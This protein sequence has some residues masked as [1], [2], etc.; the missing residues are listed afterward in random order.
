MK[1]YWKHAISL[2][3]SKSQWLMTD[4]HRWCAVSYSCESCLL[5]TFIKPW[6]FK[7]VASVQLKERSSHKLLAFPSSARQ[8]FAERAQKWDF[9]IRRLL[10]FYDNKYNFHRKHKNRIL[11]LRSQTV[12]I[13]VIFKFDCRLRAVSLL[14]KN[15]KMA[16]MQCWNTIWRPPYLWPAVSVLNVRHFESSFQ[17]F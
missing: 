15:F 9:H 11:L 17:R 14:L 13:V 12:K 5:R 4:E 8:N 2:L 16:N 3:V 6:F 1:F 7:S 10:L